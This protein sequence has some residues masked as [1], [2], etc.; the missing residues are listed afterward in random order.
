MTLKL[1]YLVY[2]VG[3]GSQLSISFGWHIRRGSIYFWNNSLCGLLS[4]QLRGVRAY[5]RRC[6]EQKSAEEEDPFSPLSAWLDC[7]R[8]NV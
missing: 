7:L 6:N 1:S 3:L 4:G 5:G 2:Q 8:H